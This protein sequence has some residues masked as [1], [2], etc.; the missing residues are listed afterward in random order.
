MFC[1]QE[2]F[3]SSNTEAITDSISRMSEMCLR[4]IT[5][6]EMVLGKSAKCLPGLKLKQQ[7]GHLMDTLKNTVNI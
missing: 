3:V 1:E 6:T 2:H 4:K 5:N 7:L